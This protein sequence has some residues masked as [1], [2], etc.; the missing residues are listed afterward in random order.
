MTMTNKLKQVGDP[1][2]SDEG[3]YRFAVSKECFGK[4]KKFVRTKTHE[5][6][7]AAGGAQ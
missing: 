2:D 6:A 3:T 7:L 4:G 1:D 5:C